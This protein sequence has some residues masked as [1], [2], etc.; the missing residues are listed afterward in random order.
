MR[1][2]FSTIVAVRCFYKIS[3][4]MYNSNLYNWYMYFKK[5]IQLYNCIFIFVYA[6]ILIVQYLMLFVI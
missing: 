4:D 2:K 3:I 1:I 6:I 5:V